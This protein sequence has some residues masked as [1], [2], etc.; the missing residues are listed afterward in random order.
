[1]SRDA[2][3]CPTCGAKLFVVSDEQEDGVTTAPVLEHAPLD[4]G[5]DIQSVNEQLFAPPENEVFGDDMNFAAN[6][7][8]GMSV[9]QAEPNYRAS[10]RAGNQEAV[11]AVKRKG[12][13]SR[14]N[15]AAASYTEFS[16]YAKGGKKRRKSF[17]RKILSMLLLVGAVGGALYFLL[18]L[19]KLPPGELPPIARPEVVPA[20]TN[21]PVKQETRSLQTD[22]IAEPGE[23]AISDNTLPSFT[24]ERTPSN[25]SIVGS[26]VNVRAD[27]TT[28][29][30]RV[31]RLSVG[32]RV[33]VIG[34]FNVPSGQYSGI[35]YNIRTGGK[36]GWVYGRYL[37]PL[38]SGLPAGY[39]SALLKSFGSNKSQLIEALG[40]PSRS[41]S[42][43]LEWQGLTATVKGDDITRIRLNNPSRELQNGLKVGMSQTALLQV[44]GYPSSVNGKTLN[45]NENGKTGLSVQL[46]RNNAISTITI[47]ELK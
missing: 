17:G 35:W 9:Y 38:G 46:D 32:T 44:M 24:P 19:R 43:S 45:Y 41:T 31:T 34:T 36:E 4:N 20:M 5:D 1:M 3:Y 18:G 2:F 22:T 16:K 27:H 7:S 21:E 14:A 12:I 37:Q 47:N 30:S 33:E 39:S 29:S 11:M 13:G 23:I 15:E 10:V 42:S 25:G 26:N 6:D 8:D 40:Q 28:S